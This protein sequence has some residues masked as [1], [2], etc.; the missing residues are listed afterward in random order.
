MFYDKFFWGNKIASE[1][2]LVQNSPISITKNVSNFD[3]LTFSLPFDT[4]AQENFKVVVYEEQWREST[5][6]FSGYVY[7]FEPRLDVNA[8]LINVT[9]NSE[10]EY[11]SKRKFLGNFSSTGTIQ[12][13]WTAAVAWYNALWDEWVVESPITWNT[14]REARIWW[15]FFTF[16]NEL[17]GNNQW[18]VVDGVITIKERIWVDRTDKN[19]P[20]TFERLYFTPLNSNISDLSIVSESKQSNIAIWVDKN[21]NKVVLPSVLPTDGITWV[22]FGQFNNGDLTQKTQELLDA[23]SKPLTKYNFGIVPNTSKADVGDKVSVIIDWLWPR[24][25]IIWD[26]E[27][28]NKTIVYD[29]GTKA[30]TIS[31]SETIRNIRTL[32]SVLSWLQRDVD[33]LKT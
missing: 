18:D 33:I 20:N 31:V 21:G 10:K 2:L 30:E 1:Y 7:K 26:L 11:L 12:Q 19:N 13:V 8:K 14:T 22:V 3:V 29:R 5:K 17:A 32:S 23:N 15:D 6:I 28:T 27:V 4:L 16:F 25:N 9:C 24:Y